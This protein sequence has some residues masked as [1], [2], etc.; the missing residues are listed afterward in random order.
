MR[1]GESQVYPPECGCSYSFRPKWGGAGP[2]C[3]RRH[4]A[5]GA[6]ANSAAPSL[7][8]NSSTYDWKTYNALPQHWRALGHGLTP[9]IRTSMAGERAHNI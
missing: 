9:R 7:T 2:H 6:P 3:A 1:G 5:G 8:H 4:S